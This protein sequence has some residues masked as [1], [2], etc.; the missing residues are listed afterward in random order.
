MPNHTD[1]ARAALPA[2][3]GEAVKAV[4]YFFDCMIAVGWR[5]GPA[6]RFLRPNPTVMPLE[7]LLRSKYQAVASLE[8]VARELACS[9]GPVASECRTLSRHIDRFEEHEAART[10]WPNLAGR[11]ITIKDKADRGGESAPMPPVRSERTNEPTGGEKKQNEEAKSASGR[12]RRKGVPQADT[13]NCVDIWL[14]KNAKADPASITRKAVAAAT[15]AS[16]GAVSKTPAWI[17][18]CRR[19]DAEAKRR[20]REVPLTDTMQASVPANSVR[21]DQL[22]AAIKEQQQELD[23]EE[24]S[25]RRRG[26]ADPVKHS[27]RSS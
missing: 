6:A 21:C 18:F 2:L 26:R 1:D 5:P 9:D 16:T 24:R 25:H 10:L 11:L 3:I 8:A 23:D 7:D 15:G 22:A 20:L 14:S 27:R 13:D 12:N 17:A 4:D 19:R